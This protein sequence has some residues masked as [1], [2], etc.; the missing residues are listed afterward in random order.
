MNKLVPLTFL[1]SLSSLSSIFVY[2]RITDKKE[3]RKPIEKPATNTLL[4]DLEEVL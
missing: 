4:P 3:S 2:R 1:V